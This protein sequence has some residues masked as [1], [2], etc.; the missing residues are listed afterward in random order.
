[1][2]KKVDYT[3]VNITDFDQHYLEVRGTFGAGAAYFG[4]A[5]SIELNASSMGV[6]VGVNKYIVGHK[7]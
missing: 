5:G 2:T 4:K 1:M 6:F 3:H 7:N